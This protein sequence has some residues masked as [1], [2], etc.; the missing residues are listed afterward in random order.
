MHGAPVTDWLKRALAMREVSGLI[1]SR[2]GH[3]TLID[4]K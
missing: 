4:C 3:K 1:S 2:G